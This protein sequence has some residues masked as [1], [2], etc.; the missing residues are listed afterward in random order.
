MKVHFNGAARTV[1]GS[2]YLFEINGKRFLLECGFFQ[3]KRADSNLKNKYFSFDPKTV[4]AVIL[5]HAHIDHSGN[6]PNLVKN[7][8]EGE[9]FATPATADLADIMLRDSGHIQEY[10]AAYVNKKRARRGEPPIE[11]LYTEADAAKV[12]SHFHPVPYNQT[13]E[14]VPGVTAHL[15]D[16]GHI[17]GSAAVVLDVNENGSQFRYWFSGDIGRRDLPLLRDPV[18]P[19]GADYLMMECTYGDKAHEN[20]NA[21]FEEFREVAIRTFKRGGKLIVPAFAVGRTQELVYS[22]NRMLKNG[23]IQPVPIFVDSP[24][25]VRASDIFRKHNDLFDEETRQFVI[26]GGHPALDF[27]G[28]TYTNNVEES[29]ALNDRHEPMVIISASGMAEAGRILHHL[30][31]NIENPRNTIAIVGWCAPDT[32]G[33]RLA[34]RQTEVKIFGVKYERRAEIVTIGGFSAHAGQNQLLDY[35]AASRA[36]LRQIVL[37]HAEDDAETAFRAKLEEARLPSVHYPARSEILEFH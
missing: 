32:L 17:L 18:L 4:D 3:G 34:E 12:A 9:I 11:P 15:V 28:L 21:A 19:E 33:R 16:A 10:D 29:K 35:A 23:D 2:Q 37:V 31:N 30:K 24:L 6:L 20:P 8:Y 22:L 7:G 5:S 27:P 1:T 36:S 13:F 14:P 26:K 25:A